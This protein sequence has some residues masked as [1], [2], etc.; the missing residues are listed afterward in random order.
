MK[1]PKD[2]KKTGRAFWKRVL[3]EYQLEEAHDLQRL[4]MAAC[5][6]D[7]ID[8]AEQKIETDGMFVKDR[9][10]QLKENPAGKV[11]RDN[12]IIFCR[13]I[14]ELALDLSEDTRPPRQY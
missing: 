9:Y 6:L 1:Y 13:I 4:Q 12:R 14:R 5:C 3:T 11:V 7:D 10:D 8:D 2:L